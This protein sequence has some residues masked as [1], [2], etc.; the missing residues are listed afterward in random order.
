M[1]GNRVYVP[2][3]R[4]MN[5]SLVSEM[6]RICQGGFPSL[7]GD[8]QHRGQ[9]ILMTT[10]QYLL[11]AKSLTTALDSPGQGQQKDGRNWKGPRWCLLCSEPYRIHHS[12]HTPYFFVRSMHTFYFIITI[13]FVMLSLNMVIFQEHFF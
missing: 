7:F 6:P 3:S 9:L 5:G 1:L 4:F 2:K 8:E 13:I 12:I 11:T 10:K